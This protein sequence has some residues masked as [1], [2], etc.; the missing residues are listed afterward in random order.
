MNIQPFLQVLEQ[1]NPQVT[2]VDLEG[3]LSNQQ[4]I[5]L[6]SAIVKFNLTPKSSNLITRSN[7]IT[8]NRSFIEDLIDG[9]RESWECVACIVGI[10]G[11]LF[12]L[13]SSMKKMNISLKLQSQLEYVSFFSLY[14]ICL[15]QVDKCTH[16]HGIRLSIEPLNRVLLTAPK[17]THNP[18]D[19]SWIDPINMSDIP[20][21]DIN[22]PRYIH[23]QGYAIKANSVLK[24]IL[25][26]ELATFETSPLFNE[27]LCAEDQAMLDWQIENIFGMDCLQITRLTQNI[28]AKVAAFINLFNEDIYPLLSPE[29]NEEI[30]AFGR[31]RQILA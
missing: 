8:L 10:L 23:L 16:P 11:I 22:S 12:L 18:A 14:L 19:N 1:R 5:D 28:D 7:S 26:R 25:Q 29:F 20:N 30:Q 6:R 21:G 17:N 15:I 9:R 27:D 2:T 31:N 3:T 24:K 4:A 13:N